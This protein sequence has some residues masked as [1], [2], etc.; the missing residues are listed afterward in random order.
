MIK[1]AKTLVANAVAAFANTVRRGQ[2]AVKSDKLLEVAQQV[3]NNVAGEGSS[4]MENDYVVF[5]KDEEELKKQLVGMYFTKSQ[6]DNKRP[7][8]GLIVEVV[9]NKR[10]ITLRLFSGPFTRGYR[11]LNAAGNG[12][13]DEMLYPSGQPADDFRQSMASMYETWK[14]YCGKIVHVDARPAVKVWALKDGATPGA[15]GRFDL[16]DDYTPRDQRIGE[17][18]YSTQEAVETELGYK[19]DEE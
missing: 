10:V 13:G 16:K 14:S 19:F 11:T 2:E 4:L 17:Y 1:R 8:I 5:P 6:K 15:D 18:S 3:T 7:S 9:R 12:P